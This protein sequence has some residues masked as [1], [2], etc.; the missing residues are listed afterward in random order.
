[1]QLSLKYTSNEMSESRD[2]VIETRVD[3][4]ANAERHL[5]YVQPKASLLC[6]FSMEPPP[7]LRGPFCGFTVFILLFV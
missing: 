1:M 4:R 5:S 6:P 7:G 2:K 3:G